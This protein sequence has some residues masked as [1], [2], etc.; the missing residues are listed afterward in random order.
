MECMYVG[1]YHYLLY[2]FQYSLLKAFLNY[3]LAK[4]INNGE[5]VGSKIRYGY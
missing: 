1:H 3:P 2:T 4:I 5:N